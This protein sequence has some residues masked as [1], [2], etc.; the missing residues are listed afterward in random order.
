MQ[1]LLC[2]LFF[3]GLLLS[4]IPFIN[5][6]EL[7][8]V[9]QS[10]RRG[11]MT[12]HTRAISTNSA[13]THTH[14]PLSSLIILAPELKKIDKNSARWALLRRCYPAHCATV[15]HIFNNPDLFSSKDVTALIHKPH[16]MQ[17]LDE[18]Y[19]KM[20]EI[21]HNGYV[22][23]IHAQEN[24][25]HFAQGIFNYLQ[26]KLYQKKWS[27]FS[28]VHSR[29]FEKSLPNEDQETQ[30]LKTLTHPTGNSSWEL[31][32]NHMLTGNFKRP[33]VSSMHYL[34]NNTSINSDD[35]FLAVR[36]PFLRT[37]MPKSIYKKYE[38]EIHELYRMYRKI[39]TY[40][41]AILIGIKPEHLTQSVVATIE[42]GKKVTNTVYCVNTH[43]YKATNNT[44]AVIE[45]LQERNGR[46][47][48]PY[49]GGADSKFYA[50]DPIFVLATTQDTHG[51]M[52][53]AHKVVMHLC[54]HTVRDAPSPEW[55][56]FEQKK[57]ALLAHIVQDV[58]TQSGL[59]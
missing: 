9:H 6:G 40:G 37:S 42:A 28:Y 55:I 21:E 48:V 8:R 12:L 57:D 31:Y 38:N 22:A 30:R 7:S 46:L 51:V 32:T 16:F 36:S 59:R 20:H 53:P 27:N 17:Y 1:Y 18:L 41:S 39:T 13:R 24:Q 50:S 3:S 35:C 33:F 11:S 56:D 23:F 2:T 52:N 14:P 4:S 54:E 19:K 34:L 29:D 43:T 58:K 5:A 15:N 10:L 25:Y 44:E 49:D 45:A 47:F 26:D